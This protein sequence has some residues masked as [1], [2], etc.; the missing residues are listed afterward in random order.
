MARRK[1]VC[2]EVVSPVRRVETLAKAER[3]TKHEQEGLF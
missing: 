2:R 1:P 3:K